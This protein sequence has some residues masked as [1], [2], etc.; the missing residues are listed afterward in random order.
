[1]P[2]SLDNLFTIEKN[3]NPEDKGYTLTLKNSNISFGGKTIE[4]VL[5]FTLNNVLIELN[6]CSAMIKAE[7]AENKVGA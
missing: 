3:T 2:N 7:N 6:V 4:E 5:E 1:M